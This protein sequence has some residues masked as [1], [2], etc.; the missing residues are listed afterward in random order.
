MLTFKN[1]TLVFAILGVILV[2]LTIRYGLSYGWCIALVILYTWPLAYGSYHIGS[3]FY[4]PVVCSADTVLREVALSF[5]DGPAAEH[6]PGVLRILER[7]HI[8]AAF[9]CIGNRIAGNEDMLKMVHQQGHLIGNHSYAHGILFDLLSAR[10]MSRDLRQMDD[11]LFATVGLRPRLFRPPYG[12]TN[13][14]LRKAVRR[15]GYTAVGWNVRSLDTVIQDKEKL[16]HR[17]TDA[18]RPGAIVL[19]HDTSFTTLSILDE[20]IG[21]IHAEGYAIVRLD[22]MCKLTPYV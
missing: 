1:T 21:R 4:F 5:D 18:L 19:L 11:A 15:G 13:P 16:L 14:N 10:K 2:G 3:D 20:L 8:E 12:V 17:I 7:H 9:F 22:K 6:T